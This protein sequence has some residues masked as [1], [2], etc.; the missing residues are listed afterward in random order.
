MRTINLRV[1]E[2]SEIDTMQLYMILAS[3][4]YEQGK[5]SLGQAAELANLSKRAFAELLSSY[6][7][8]VFNYPA[9]DLKNETINV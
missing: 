5:L 2:M 4:L 1:P 9:S 3:S 7:V 6:N 8:S